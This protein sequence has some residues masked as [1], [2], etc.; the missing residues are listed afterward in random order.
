M[1]SG[2]QSREVKSVPPHPMENA[3]H[4]FVS[5]CKAP[6]DQ[7]LPYVPSHTRRAKVSSTIIM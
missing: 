5:V 2:I 6:P 1:N 3:S 4:C 7:V